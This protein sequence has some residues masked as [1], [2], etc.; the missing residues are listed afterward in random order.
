ME[1]EE[2]VVVRFC[3]SRDRE[4]HSED[5]IPKD[6]EGHLNRELNL[7]FEVLFDRVKRAQTGEFNELLRIILRRVEEISETNKILI[8]IVGRILTKL[9]IIDRILRYDNLDS[10]N[11]KT[12]SRVIVRIAKVDSELC[13]KMTF[14]LL[15]DFKNVFVS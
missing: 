10:M 9:D 5:I 2:G 15:Q 14:T 8:L 6:I 12:L 3:C 11:Q 4:V 7:I 13:S 1:T